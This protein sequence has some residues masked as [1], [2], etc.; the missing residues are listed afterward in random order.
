MNFPATETQ[1]SKTTS[2]PQ[3]PGREQRRVSSTKRGSHP[4]R[5]PWRR[6]TLSDIAKTISDIILTKSDIV[7]KIS[8]LVPIKPN[9]DFPLFDLVHKICL[10]VFPTNICIYHQTFLHLLSTQFALNGGWRVVYW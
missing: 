5:Q 7:K 6:K 8:D 10:I 3:L 2:P 1:G 9:L 4:H